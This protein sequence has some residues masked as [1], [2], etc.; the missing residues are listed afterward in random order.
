MTVDNEVEKRV[1]RVFGV[2]SHMRRYP[3]FV[4]LL[5]VRRSG[6]RPAADH[7]TNYTSRRARRRVRSSQTSKWI[8]KPMCA[9]CAVK[10]SRFILNT[11]GFFAKVKTL[12]TFKTIMP[13]GFCCN[14]GSTLLFVMFLNSKAILL[15]TTNNIRWYYCVYL[16][17]L[18]R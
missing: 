6:P 17:L 16:R 8:T 1:T 9:S 13:S 11:R 4:W 10:A 2:Q 18:K 12:N 15:T 7:E 3:C 5:P 14:H